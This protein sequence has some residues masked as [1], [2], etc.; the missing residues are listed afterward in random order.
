MQGT[1]SPMIRIHTFSGGDFLG[2]RISGGVRRE[3][4]R[5]RHRS[6][7]R[8]FFH[9]PGRPGRERFPSRP[10]S[11]PTPIW[12]T[13]K[14]FRPSGRSVPEVPIFLHLRPI[15]SYEAVEMQARA[16][17][18]PSVGPFPI[19]IGSMA[20]GEESDLRG[21]A[22]SRS[23]MHPGHAPG[24]VILYSARRKAWPLW[25]MWSSR[26]PSAGPIWWGEIS[27]NSWNPSGPRF[28]PSPTK[29]ASSLAM[30][31]RLL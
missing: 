23:G 31:P 8:C 26:E 15:G 22:A 21:S 7:G 1:D 14:G 20:H 12:I 25:G 4:P 17:N 2:K 3:R 30:G 5:N 19:R 28:S 29:P 11:S 6:R 24:H 9:G 27:T 18:L 13:W 10:S 16:F